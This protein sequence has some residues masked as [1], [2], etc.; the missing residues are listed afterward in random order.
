M[1][2]YRE[3]KKLNKQGNVIPIFERIPADMDTPVGAF[4]KL[5]YGKRDSFLLESIEGGEKLARYSFIGYDPFLVIEGDV[6]R[7]VLYQGQHKQALDSNPIDF[8]KEL[9]RYYRPVKVA[10]LPR[11]TGGGVG[12][13]SY[14][15]IRWIENLPDDNQETIG[16]PAMRLGLFRHIVVFDHLKQEILVIANILHEPGESGFK[17]SYDNARATVEQMIGRLQSARINVPKETSAKTRVK[18]HYTK[19][20]FEHMVRRAKRYIKEGDIF[21]VVLSQRWQVNSDLSPL[22]LY[23]RLRRINPSPYMF[24]LNFGDC[25][26]IGS[27]PE[28]MVRVEGK[29]IETRPIAGTRPRGK[30]EKEDKRLTINLL[31]DTKEL[32]EHTMLLD[33]GRNDLGRVSIPGSVEVAQKMIVEK[34]SHVIH[35]VSSVIGTIKPRVAPLDGMFSC[36]PAGTVSGAPKIRAMEIIDELEKEKRGVYAGAVA[37]LD[38]WGNLDSCIAIRTVVKKGRTYYV[39][40]GAGIVADSKPSREYRETE[41]KAQA[42]LAAIT[43]RDKR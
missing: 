11:F 17:S 14:D 24:L 29:S 40:A 9:F 16:L 25:S 10:G 7:V 1:I 41:Y 19:A 35:L 4:L 30:N 18:A 42:L 15:T 5:A 12:Y 6:N 43:G 38:F 27:S 31:A 28:M 20:E 32:A 39:Q 21:Q 33:L 13:F 34:Y 2:S 26:I 22:S 3:A 36:F 23:R 8:V 37:Y